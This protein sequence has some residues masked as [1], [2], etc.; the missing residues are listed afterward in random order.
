VRQEVDASPHRRQLARG[1]YDQRLDA[2]RV[3][4]ER[5]RQ[6]CDPGT[7]DQHPHCH[8]PFPHPGAGE[9]VAIRRHKPPV[10]RSVAMATLALVSAAR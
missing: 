4:A 8:D 6:A 3:Q 10:I 2:R 5:G 7:G 9:L 1:L